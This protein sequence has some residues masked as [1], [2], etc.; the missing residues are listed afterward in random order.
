MQRV[1]VA[2]FADRSIGSV[3]GGERQRAILARALA[4]DAPVLLLDEPTASLDVTRQVET[5]ALVRELVADGKTAVAAIHDLDLAARFC[6]EL[7]LLSRGDVVASGP[8]ENVLDSDTI[9]DAFD[10]RAV[11]GRDAI[12]GSPTVTALPDTASPGG[13][14]VHVV[15]NGH[16][17]ARALSRLV[18]AGFESSIGPVPAT[19]VAAI[20]ARA[21][22]AETMDAPVFRPLDETTVADLE[23]RLDRVDATVFAGAGEEYEPVIDHVAADR[24]VVAVEEA[25]ADGPRPLAAFDRV[26]TTTLDGLTD[27]VVGAVGSR[28]S[29]QSAR[30]S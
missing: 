24:T 2:R 17:A 3:S 28:P 23:D 27:A 4:Q 1:D 16:E 25:V 12:T 11:V 7:A 13:G 9:S 30:F 15:G 26:R 19:D 8:P 6:D 5:L 21:L 10:G 18:D 20:S 22:G 29:E 14:R